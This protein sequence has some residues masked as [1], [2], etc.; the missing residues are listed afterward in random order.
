MAYNQSRRNEIARALG[1]QSYAAQRKAP[2]AELSQRRESL[3]A[4]NAGTYAG[5]GGRDL[6][7]LT[8]TGKVRHR[9]V[10]ATPDQTTVDTRSAIVVHSQLE[11]AA[12]AGRQVKASVTF[13]SVKKYKDRQVLAHAEIGLFS[14]GGY[15]AAELLE[16]I[17]HPEP[18]SGRTAGDVFGTLEMLANR[19]PGVDGAKGVER[20]HLDLYDAPAARAERDAGRPSIA[21]AKRAP[22]RKAA[23]KAPAKKAPKRSP[24][25]RSPYW[26]SPYAKGRKR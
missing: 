18:G 16:M 15:S 19:L 9:Q 26:V 12:R 24:A 11:K 1:Y 25:K 13:G 4:A 2:A 22:A 8:S 21:E 6:R 20:V 3:K 5:K 14:H 10:T 23:K 17:D 7:K